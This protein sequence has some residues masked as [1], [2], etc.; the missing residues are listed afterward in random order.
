ML[1]EM[2]FKF[3]EENDGNTSVPT[4]I[5]NNLLEHFLNSGCTVEDDSANSLLHNETH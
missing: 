1:F 2:P 3:K 5:V 4:H